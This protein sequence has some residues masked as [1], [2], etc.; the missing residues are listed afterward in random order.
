M[1]IL[2]QIQILS[3]VVYVKCA[4]L[5]VNYLIAKSFPGDFKIASKLVLLMTYFLNNFTHYGF[6]LSV[7]VFKG[8]DSLHSE[9]I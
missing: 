7:L 8:F 4:M 2:Q 9:V 5:Y 1:I 3:H 6:I